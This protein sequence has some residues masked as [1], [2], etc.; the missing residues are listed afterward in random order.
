MARPPVR[1]GS[2]RTTKRPAK[3]RPRAS[4]K[5]PLPIA[6]PE[7]LRA[8]ATAPTVTP[9]VPEG[10]SPAHGLYVYGVL[11][12]EEALNFGLIGLG[13][14][15]SEVWTVL[16]RGLGAVV[17]KGPRGVPD[18]TRDNLLAH[19][20]VQ[21]AVIH[22]HTLLPMAFG[23][24]FPGPEDVTE[25]LRS[26]HD[27]FTDV[28]SRLEGH[29]ELGL[30]VLW[31]QD[32]AARELEQVD[33]ELARLAGQPPDSPAR[34]EY[35]R[36]LESAL[37]ERAQHEGN[38]IVETLRPVAAA[39]RVVS[40]VGERMLLN[41]AFLVARE[42]EAAFDARVKS[43]A[44]KHAML[45]FQFTGPWAPYHFADIRLRLKREEPARDR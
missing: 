16:Y 3:R 21:E 42:Q 2:S 41:A 5:P 34:L 37:R 26:A 43:L 45:T 39:T 20:R 28:L 7:P 12:T 13:V 18:P 35:E 9:A 22:G 11:R 14:P 1:K 36:R 44:A 17:S 4:A 33:A 8:A 27:A 29:I 32:R 19:H 30:K 15:P 6:E 23:L 40:P 31:D 38:S 10:L 25:L 24:T